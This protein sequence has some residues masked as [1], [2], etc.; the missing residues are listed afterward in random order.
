MVCS[1]KAGDNLW[2]GVGK[3]DRGLCPAGLG[4][5]GQVVTDRK[6]ESQGLT[7]MR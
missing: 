5:E 4:L 6:E 3:E 2:P 1:V 7:G